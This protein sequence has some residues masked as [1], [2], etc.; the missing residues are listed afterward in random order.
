MTY[1]DYLKV[2]MD[3]LET[4]C[5]SNPSDLSNLKHHKEINSLIDKSVELLRLINKVQV[6]ANDEVNQKKLKFKVT[7]KVV[8]NSAPTKPAK[9]IATAIKKGPVQNRPLKTNSLSKG[10]VSGERMRATY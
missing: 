9:A 10:T 3:E 8:L 6:S 7:H 1:Q 5:N 4:K 2:L